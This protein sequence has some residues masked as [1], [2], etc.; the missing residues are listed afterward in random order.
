MTSIAVRPTQQQTRIR[1][2]PQP[3]K[4][5]AVR[6]PRIASVAAATPPFAQDQEQFANLV[7]ENVLGADWATRTETADVSRKIGR[8]FTASGVR[9]RRG[10]VDFASFYSRPRS[11]G[12]RMA[13]YAKLAHPLGREAVEA[14]LRGA[15]ARGTVRNYDQISDFIVTSC[16]GY[17]A[18]GLDI[19]LARD[20]G[21]PGNVRRVIVGHMGCFAAIVGLRQA[22]AAVRAHPGANVM[23]LSIELSSLHFMPSLDP[24]VLTCMSLFGD[25]AAAL[26]LTDDPTAD[27][28]EL[29][30][31]Y[32]GADFS[33]AD[34]MSWK[35]T[36]TGFVMSLSPRVP[37]SLKRSVSGAVEQLL[38][39]HGLGVGDVAHWL[40]HP[41][42][43]SILDV[44]QDKLE[45]SDEQMADSRQVLADNGNCSSATILLVLERLLRS[46]RARKGEWAVMMAFGPGLT[47][48]TCL[49]RF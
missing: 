32:C 16:T 20:L 5:P 45:L 3:V 31:T 10:V 22:L 9:Q 1:T 29:V 49:L 19:S 34:Q 11:T 24:Q 27:G 41:G 17:T 40:V 8:L 28:P 15:A 42:G 37:F 39:P 44:V 2:I 26:M 13:E 23:M 21:M 7:R 30:D 4:A 47:I 36:D 38:A 33:T 18:P 6:H 14:S 43:P 46:G 25:A 48:E 35:I 12:E